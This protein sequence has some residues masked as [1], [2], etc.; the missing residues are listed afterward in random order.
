MKTIINIGLALSIF[1]G[2]VREA[3]TQERKVNPNP[4]TLTM[5]TEE[6]IQI[7]F[8]MN[9]MYYKGD[10]LS[11]DVW[12]S[13]LGVMETAV[14][15]SEIEGGKKVSYKKF[16]ELQEDKVKVKVTSLPSEDILIID[17]EGTTQ[18]SSDRI[19]FQISIPMLEVTF[20]VNDLDL[21]ES[22][23]DLNI[24]SLWKEINEKFEDQ[25]RRNL[26]EGSGEFKYNNA[27]ISKIDGFSSR[28][29]SIEFSAGIGLGY[30]RDRFVPDFGFKM[31]LNLFDRLGNEYIEF[32]F[33]Y[34]QQ[35]FYSED[36][37]G[38]FNLDTNGFL[39]GFLNFE[40]FENSEYGIAIGAKIHGEGDFYKGQ[41]WKLSAFGQ[42]R[43]SG[44]TYTPEIMFTN[45]F[46]D[47]F[48]AFRLGFTF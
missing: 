40:G 5:M 29:E 15:S 3:K 41:T 33:L 26:Y 4:D 23:K 34:Q 6:G 31:G 24:E 20:Q 13:A 28:P 36:L 38:D 45:D 8:A 17:K 46:K 14:M 42:K 19:A 9:R 1:I 32:G 44:F 47:I 12:K 11:N 27:S 39:S 2:L 25:G 16:K 18:Y 7:T 43:G 10:Y 22:V 37:E 30:Y 21:L 48:P 35:Y